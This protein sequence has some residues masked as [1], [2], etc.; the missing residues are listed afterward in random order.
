[1][2]GAQQ[3]RRVLNLLTGHMNPT[4]QKAVARLEPLQEVA[5]YF[6]PEDNADIAFAQ[7][8]DARDSLYL[9]GHYYFQRVLSLHEGLS[10]LSTAWS[11]LMQGEGDTDDVLEVSGALVAAF[12]LRGVLSF[13]SEVIGPPTNAQV[14][15]LPRPGWAEDPIPEPVKLA[16]AEFVTACRHGHKES[17]TSWLSQ[18]AVRRIE[19][20]RGLVAPEAHLEL[21]EA[22]L[23]Q[24]L[25]ER[26]S[27]EA[28]QLGNFT[29]LLVEAGGILRSEGD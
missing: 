13:A 10:I 1:M 19:W 28:W 8:T 14:I 23:T 25:K 26:A 6:N 3:M 7:I 20:L 11:G 2:D 15:R 5:E 21:A 24:K 16:L 27:A 29:A 12:Q 17:M 18:T 22:E 9:D 4:V